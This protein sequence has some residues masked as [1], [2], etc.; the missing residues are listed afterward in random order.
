MSDKVSGE[1]PK[2]KSELTVQFNAGI[3]DVFGGCIGEKPPQSCPNCGAL[4]DFNITVKKVYSMTVTEHVT[5][6]SE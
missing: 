2:C 1:C 4:L 3:I 5:V 6:I